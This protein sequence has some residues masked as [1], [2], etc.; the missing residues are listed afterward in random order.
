MQGQGDLEA[1]GKAA[2]GWTAEGAAPGLLATALPGSRLEVRLHRDARG[3]EHVGAVRPD[4]QGSGV[5]EAVELAS[6]AGQVAACTGRGRGVAQAP[7]APEGAGKEAAPPP[8]AAGQA[9]ERGSS[10]RGIG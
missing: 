6:Q 3:R 1:V 4:P 9:Q 10:A 7:E 8:R 5:G 2:I